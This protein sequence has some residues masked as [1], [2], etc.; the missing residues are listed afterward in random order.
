MVE[1]RFGFSLVVLLEKKESFIKT[2]NR[3]LYLF[4]IEVHAF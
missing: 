4:T 2:Q 1:T 3:W